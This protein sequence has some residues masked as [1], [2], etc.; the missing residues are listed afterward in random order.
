MM[1]GAPSS[2]R[3]VR[4]HRARTNSRTTVLTHDV[5]ATRAY[6]LWLNAGCADG[7][8][9]EFWFEAERQLQD[10]S[11]VETPALEVVHS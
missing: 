2:H 5:I 4:S 7:R 1:N 6:E 11:D 3:H 10:D 8:D 9:L